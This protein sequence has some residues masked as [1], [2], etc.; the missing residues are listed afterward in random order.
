MPTL[1]TVDRMADDKRNDPGEPMPF[2]KVLRP[3]FGRAHVVP[4]EV[5]R[6]V[7]SRPRPTD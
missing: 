6:Q 2:R 5:H 4:A 7:R 1:R 3:P